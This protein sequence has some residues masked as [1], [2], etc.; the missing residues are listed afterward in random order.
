MSVNTKKANGY[1]RQKFPRCEK[2]A[3]YAQLKYF[4]GMT[5]GH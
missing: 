4:P 1:S 2:D 3:G 5:L